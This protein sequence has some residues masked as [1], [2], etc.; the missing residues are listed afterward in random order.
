MSADTDTPKS[1]HSESKAIQTAGD[2]RV[3]YDESDDFGVDEQKLVRKLDRHLIP[4]VM[5]LCESRVG[6]R[7]S[8]TAA[9]ARS[10][11]SWLTSNI[12]DTFSFLDRFVL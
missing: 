4:L 1:S 11:V 8:N 9:G 5:L 7:G 2:D 10:T 12:V 6:L 3:A